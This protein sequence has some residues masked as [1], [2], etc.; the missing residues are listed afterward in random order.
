MGQDY[1]AITAK[2]TGSFERTDKL[3]ETEQISMVS[4][5]L[6]TLAYGL[7]FF[8]KIKINTDNE[9]SVF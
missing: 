3:P 1:K 7:I 8:K 5:H 2:D 6:N 9:L 4:A